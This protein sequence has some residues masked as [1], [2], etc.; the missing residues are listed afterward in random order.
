[1]ISDY[2][3]ENSSVTI[4][5]ILP[6]LKQKP[7]FWNLILQNISNEDEIQWKMTSKYKK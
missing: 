3:K 1:M 7:K 2:Y 6:N 5:Q 4:G